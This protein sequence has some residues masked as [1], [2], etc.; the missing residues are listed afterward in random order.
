VRRSSAG[1]YVRAVRSQLWI[2]VLLGS[3][4]AFGPLSI[5]M[6][7]P[8]LP[9]LSRSLHVGASVGQLTLTACLV[10]LALGQLGAGPVSD[11]YGRRRPVLVGLAAYVVATLLCAIA[12]SAAALVALRLLQGLAGGVSLVVARA[13]ARDL[14]DGDALARFL[15]TLML[16]NGLAPILAPVLGAQLL[17]ATSWRGVFVVLGGLGALLFVGALVGLHE[18][19]RPADRRTGG[20]AEVRTTVGEL[21][22]DRAF[23]GYLAVLGLSFGAMFAYIAGSP[24]VV[25]TIHHASPQA[26]S[27]VFAL[28]GIGIVAASQTNAAL[29]SRFGTTRLLGLGV[30]ASACGGFALL[31]VVS[32]GIG[33]AGIV[34]CLFVVVASIGVIIPNATALSLADHG[35][36]AGSASGLIGIFQF[37]VGAAAAPLVGIAGTHSAYPM[38]IVIAVLAGSSLLLVRRT[39]NDVARAANSIVP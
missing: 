1:E 2:V 8:A 9:A 6:Y 3:L 31:G 34:P 11:R 10:G 21:M 15:S 4:S 30:A 25:E 27:A 22:G 39:T 17:R 5:D 19:L 13:I 37:A 32:A 38:A 20:L 28:N 23:V 24:F 29:L 26:Y 7:L 33:L 36:V 14:H 35:R 12:P 16:V 18:T